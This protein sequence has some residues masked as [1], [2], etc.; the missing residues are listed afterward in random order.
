MADIPDWMGGNS[1]TTTQPDT[2]PPQTASAS[3]PA[4]D[5]PDWLQGDG[6]DKLN[7]SLKASG[8]IPPE[9]AAKVLRVKDQTGL[10]SNFV[11][12]N[13]PQ[14]EATQNTAVA[15]AADVQ[16]QAPKVAD[17]LAEDPHHAAVAG[18]DIPILSFLERQFSYMGNQA[19]RGVYDTERSYLGGKIAAGLGTP[20]DEKRIQAIES[21]LNIDLNQKAPGPISNVFGKV[22]E[23][24]PMLVGV[25]GIGAAATAASAAL[26]PAGATAATIAAVGSATTAAV[27]AGTAAVFGASEFGSAYLDYRNRKDS[28]GNPISDSEAK[29]WAA[30]SGVLNGAA[31]LVPIGKM[32][33]KMPGLRML[34]KGGIDSIL[35][36]PTARQAFQTYIKDIGEGGLAMGGFSGIGTLV[37]SAAGTLAEMKDDP[38]ASPMQI[39]AKIF[40]PDALKE[41]AESAG[42]GLLTGGIFSGAL[43]SIRFAND[44]R[45]AMKTQQSWKDIGEAVKSS[46]MSQM[47]PD[48][49]EKVV[50]RIAP[51]QNVFI[52]M[53]KW[54][55][56][57]EGQKADPRAVFNETTS[58]T[59]AYDESMRTGT[60]LQI[61]AA[62]YATTIAPSDHAEFFNKVLKSDPVSLSAED[63]EHGNMFHVEQE[64]TNEE[65]KKPSLIQRG[66]GLVRNLFGATDQA[67]GTSPQGQKAS[68]PAL[69]A[70]SSS[71]GFRSTAFPLPE[72]SYGRSIEQHPDFIKMSKDADAVVQKYAK[73]RGVESSPELATNLFQEFHDV[74]GKIMKA[75]P[76]DRLNVVNDIKEKYPDLQNE[77]SAIRDKL[78]SDTTGGFF[79]RNIAGKYG[80][81]RPKVVLDAEE[82]QRKI[83]GEGTPSKEETKIKFTNDAA[84]KSLMSAQ[85][86]QG[87]A[88]LFDDPKAVGMKPEQEVRYLKARLEAEQ[89]ASKQMGDKIRADQDRI[90]NADR[91]GMREEI[92][93]EVN[94]Q[95]EYK[96]I[97]TLKSGTGINGADI[98]KDFP[99]FEAKRM[100]RGI[101]NK[102]TGYH[103]DLA[104]QLLGY[105]SGHELLFNIETA[106]DREQ[107]IKDKIEER[108]QAKYGNPLDQENLRNEAFKSIHNAD[109]SRLLQ[110]ELQHLASDNFAAFKGMLKALTRNVPRLNEVREQAKDMIGSKLAGDTKP[111]LYQRAESLAGREAKEFFLQGDIERAFEAKSR[112]L[113]NHELFR[114]AQVAK[115]QSEKD[116]S[117]ASRFDKD[118]VRAKLGKAGS[119]YLDQIDNIREKFDFAKESGKDTQR[120]QSLRS[121]IEDQQKQGY[122]PDIPGELLNDSYRKSYREMTND[123]LHGVVDSMR[124]IDHLATL[125]NKL[126]TAQ[127]GREFDEVKNEVIGS[128]SD[129][130]KITPEKLNKPVNLNPSLKEKIGSGIADFGAWNTK[131]EFLF[132]LLDG[133]KYHGPAWENL[134]DPMNK[135]EDFK[136]SNLREAKKSV[137]DIFNVYSKSELKDL[138]KKLIY[139]PELE[140]S[141]ITP[142][143]NKMQILM[144]ML[145]WGN[146]GNR[147]ELLRGYQWNEGQVRALW[148]NLDAR[149]LGV[150][151]KIWSFV[152]SYW[153]KI[154]EQQKRLNGLV[155]EKI[156]AD[157]FEVKAKDGSTVQ[158]DG[159]YFPLVYD[160]N[161]FTPNSLKDNAEDVKGLFG[162]QAGR[163]ATKHGWTNERVGGGGQAPS[164][165]ITTFVNHVSDVIHDLAYREPVIDAYKLMN[166]PDIKANIEAAAGKEMYKQLNPWLKRIAGDRP[167]NPLG[168]IGDLLTKIQSN[169]TTAELGFKFTS[170]AIHTT[171]YLAATREVGIGYATKGMKDFYSDMSGSWKFITDK[172]EFMRS[173]P[174]ELDRDLRNRIAS[175]KKIFNSPALEAAAWSMMR[176][177][178]IGIAGPTW[179]A[180]YRKAMDGGVKNIDVGT[181][182]DAIDYADQLVRDTKGS[183]SAK[184]IAPIMTAGG[185]LGRQFTMFLTQENL[186]ANQFMQ[187]SREF[188]I[189]HNI[190]KLIGTYAMVGF[191]PAAMNELIKGRGPK[192]DES[193]AAWL[194]KAEVLYPMATV[195]GL[196]DIVSGWSKGEFETPALEA[197]STMI[198]GAKAV[199]KDDEWSSKDYSD[200]LM[201]LGYATG[202]PTRQ[203]FRTAQYLHEWMTGEQEPSNIVEGGYRALVGKKYE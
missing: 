88:P 102:E 193:W 103:P 188:R 201:S 8:Q 37:H 31:A 11:S 30:V 114:S 112:E 85:L 121:F 75:K 76:E 29:G 178:D 129:I 93:R 182:P 48:Q 63:A 130:F 134:F 172:S 195:P 6:S 83:A 28:Q 96:A 56:Y 69:G 55:E 110:L 49:L 111:Y 73:E 39:M 174:E 161:V 198:R 57:W 17:W 190:P 192:Q 183:G 65:T 44:Y 27:T 165:A 60:D 81:M 149:D 163:A 18:Q 47:A 5:L 197:L 119:D 22:V 117:F 106:P 91:R 136:T 26:V 202:L 109:R 15:N 143:L 53:D 72:D 50:S 186:I 156:E 95:K 122:E 162:V 9:Q 181:E 177:L 144:T 92:E 70:A 135:A 52:P 141:K 152:N 21:K 147:T 94:E 59:A 148:K 89:T 160:K 171:S 120:R 62:K 137:D 84:K 151:N 77:F 33:E 159:G 196:R 25:L 3:T 36:N 87:T 169:A 78:W 167:W 35:A 97:D 164:L 46:K 131:M 100:P 118:S 14:L 150:A 79:E 16:A 105:R 12:R 1:N 145:H 2:A 45:N 138:H 170:A 132:R 66:I 184:D 126:L 99:D 41:A 107:V 80:A 124:N 199:T 185:A 191:L 180:A 158:M 115:E 187:A 166:D 116:V 168:P 82:A 104:A 64:Q 20:D 34:S 140:G 175:G 43:G 108:I 113:L 155:P 61:P 74:L 203:A 19:E 133:G 128:M 71:E 101:V 86:E 123:E 153:P 154:S 68:G 13:L 90:Q 58:N 24:T 67:E 142:N 38:S 40:S 4:S 176:N 173:R 189:D 127:E 200:A 157:P 125:K 32:M 179:L 23:G 51:D 98:A 194:A 139:T 7:A 10:P 42:T 146:E 54:Q